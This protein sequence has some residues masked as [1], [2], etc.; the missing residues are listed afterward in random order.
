MLHLSA[1]L[2]PNPKL[3]KAIAEGKLFFGPKLLVASK[4]P[5]KA[6]RNEAKRERRA[7]QK[8]MRAERHERSLR[9]TD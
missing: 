4:G 2:V 3:A 1:P 9:V 5:Y 7:K 6:G 8:Q